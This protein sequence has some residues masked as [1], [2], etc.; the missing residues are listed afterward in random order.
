LVYMTK[1]WYFVKQT[2]T[3]AYSQK[4]VLYDDSTLQH[5]ETQNTY[6]YYVRNILIMFYY[7]AYLYFI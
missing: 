3:E 7:V 5:I 4:Y 6:F 1:F 2:R